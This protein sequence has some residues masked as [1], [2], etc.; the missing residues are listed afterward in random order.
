MIKKFSFL[1][2]VALMAISASLVFTGC[3]KDEDEDV[4]TVNQED[5]LGKWTT[6]DFNIDLKIGDVSYMD[7]M[8]SMGVPAEQ[9]QGLIDMMEASFAGF[10]V[11]EL[12]FSADGVVTITP[13]GFD[14]EDTV[15]ALSNDGKVLTMYEGEDLETYEVATLTENSLVIKLVVNETEEGITTTTTV[16]F[17]F[18]K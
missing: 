8:T 15:W 3:E 6:S 5:I 7:Y 9:V 16:T 13:N 11:A 10:G 18:T 1:N 12:D 2:L 14:P 4:V 17:S